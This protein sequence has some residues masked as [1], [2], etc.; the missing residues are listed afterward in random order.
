MNIKVSSN[1]S[2]IFQDYKTNIL[3][4]KAKKKKNRFCRKSG[5]SQHFAVI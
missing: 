2:K 4:V 1:N 3:K 5:V